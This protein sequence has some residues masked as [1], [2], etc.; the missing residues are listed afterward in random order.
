M[1]EAEALRTEWGAAKDEYER[2][3]GDGADR[4]VAWVGKLGRS[5]EVDSAAIRTK[6]QCLLNYRAAHRS[7]KCGCCS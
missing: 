2:G 1:R 3:L 4:S 7:R 5:E 6:E